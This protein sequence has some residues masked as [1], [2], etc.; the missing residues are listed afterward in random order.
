[1]KR[2]THGETA[3][4]LILWKVVWEGPAGEAAKVFPLTDFS[5]LRAHKEDTN[6]LGHGNKYKLVLKPLLVEIYSYVWAAKASTSSS[7]RSLNRTI[8]NYT[9]Q[10]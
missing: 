1:M 8:H 3:E 10:E 2:K 5:H 9:H 6:A 4:C 7:P